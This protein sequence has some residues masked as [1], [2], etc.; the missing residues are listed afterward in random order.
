MKSVIT[1]MIGLLLTN[2]ALAG[3]G[4]RQDILRTA[5]AGEIVS[6]KALCPA[7]VTCITDGTVINLRFQLV[8][9][10][11]KLSLK[12]TVDRA[13]NTV[14]VQAIEQVNAKQACIAVVPDPIEESITLVMMFAPM[15]VNFLG[16][17]VSYEILP[18][19]VT[20]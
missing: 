15:T 3:N 4:T 2:T 8:S 7:D 17:D 10:C 14:D 18:E 12:Y 16:T 5:I 20:K 19:D 11:G 1:L 9:A 6:V 13:T